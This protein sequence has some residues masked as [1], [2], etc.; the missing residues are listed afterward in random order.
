MILQINLK[1]DS[2]IFYTAHTDFL[3]SIEKWML[4]VNKRFI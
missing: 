1:N 3:S 2:Y 4:N